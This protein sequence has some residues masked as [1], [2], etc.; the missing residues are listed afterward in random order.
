[1]APRKLRFGSLCA[2]CSWSP[3]RIPLKCEPTGSPRSRPLPRKS[4][5]SGLLPH[6]SWSFPFPTQCLWASLRLGNPGMPGSLK[7]EPHWACRLPAFKGV[8]NEL[9]PHR[10]VSGGRWGA[11][12]G[13]PGFSLEVREPQ[14]SIEASTLTLSHGLLVT[15][16]SQQASNIPTSHSLK[17]CRMSLLKQAL[18]RGFIIL[19]FCLHSP[20]TA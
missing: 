9:Q 18:G 3:G 19:N 20:S 7:W 5:L 8:Q 14:K 4:H 17:L 15:F 11:E 6:L 2:S 13:L 1:M 16:Q 10:V 12:D